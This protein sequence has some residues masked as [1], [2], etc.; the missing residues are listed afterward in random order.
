MLRRGEA[1]ERCNP[2]ALCPPGACRCFPDNLPRPLVQADRAWKRLWYAIESGSEWL[3]RAW[4][5]APSQ[6]RKETVARFRSLWPDE[7]VER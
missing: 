2:F 1:R 4:L 6:P 3:A 5:R 7:H